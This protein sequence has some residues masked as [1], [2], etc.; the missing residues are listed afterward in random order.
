MKRVMLAFVFVALLAA[1][2]CAA[3]VQ[4]G[5]VSKF[6]AVI[7]AMVK[8]DTDK[9]EPTGGAAVTAQGFRGIAWGAPASSDSDLC[10]VTTVDGGMAFYVRKGEKLS[11]GEAKLTNVYYIFDDGGFGGVV[12][13]ADGTNRDNYT[14]M[15]AACIAQWGESIKASG[16]NAAPDTD[17]WGIDT[18]IAQLRLKEDGTCVLYL[19]SDA[20]SERMSARESGGAAQSYAGDF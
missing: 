12:I 4:P 5:T 16:E 19:L 1:V 13:Q 17:Y 6:D 8:G 14:K 15:R 10:F 20:M 2:G 11:L 9:P 18:C 7:G 3:E